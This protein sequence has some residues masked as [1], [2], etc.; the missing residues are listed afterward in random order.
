M[1]SETIELILREIRARNY[2]RAKELLD[3]LGKELEK[4]QKYLIF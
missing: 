1:P 4:L 3:D 2:T